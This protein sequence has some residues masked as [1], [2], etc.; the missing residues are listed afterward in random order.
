[1]DPSVVAIVIP[2][3]LIQLGLIVY[4]LFDLAKRP[5]A[6]VAGNSKL[7]WVVVILVFSLIGPLAYLV[8][9]RKE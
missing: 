7:L 6:A 4:A 9:G 5:A 2:L 1:M 8:A 3:A